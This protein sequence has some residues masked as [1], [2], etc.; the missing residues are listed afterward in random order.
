[1][2]K[3][4]DKKMIELGIR[5]AGSK[6]YQEDKIWSRYS[7]DKVDI[8]EELAKVIRT[9]AKAFPLS[10]TLRALSIGSSD[11]PQFRILETAFRGG[12]Y[13]FDLEKEALDMV[14]ER[15][16][17]QYTDHVTTILDDYNRVFVDSEKVEEFLR[18]RL[19]GRRVDLITL[20]HSLYYCAEEMW[21]TI[22]SNLH[23][24][25]L[26]P[27]GAM[28]IVLM[29][30]ESDDEYTTT[31]LYNHFAGKYFGLRNNQ[32][33]L[34]LKKELKRVPAFRNSQL[35]SRTNHVR[36]FP[37]D[38]GEFMS[39]VWMILLYPNVH[40]YTLKQREEITEFVYRKFWKKKRP[41][42]QPQDHLVIYKGLGFKGFI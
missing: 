38:F 36:F 39:V 12:L 17:R 34:D 1:M 14:N 37:G 15:A 5:A 2:L 19:G 25:I 16:I 32:D 10:R 40:K 24:K 31:W 11:E 41:L 22:M 4:T 29:S 30:S 13:L 20:H 28:H 3:S 18:T 7:N 27:K 6:M 23:R 26:S 33:L 35:L 8:G 21:H 42:V 9:L